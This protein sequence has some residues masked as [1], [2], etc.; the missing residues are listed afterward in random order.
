MAH[1]HD[2]H[3]IVPFSVNLKVFIALVCLTIITVYTARHMHFGVLN[4]VV[5]MLIATVKVVIVMG[6]FM[7]LKYEGYLHKVMVATAIIFLAL[8][9]GISA[10]DVFTR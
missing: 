6:W 10:I 2:D 8:L 5:A 9:Y 3:H 4:L 1:E 7:H